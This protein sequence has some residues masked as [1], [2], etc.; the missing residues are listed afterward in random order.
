MVLETTQRVNA[1]QFWQMSQSDD[2]HQELIHGEIHEM[3][4]TGWL[5]GDVTSILS[6]H[7]QSHVLSNK[8]G[9]VTAAE[10]GFRLNDD[11]VLAPDIGFI[12]AERV[13]EKLPDGFVPL[14]PDL[15]VEVMSPSN[16]AS[17]MSQKIKLF[18]QHG[19]QLVWV[20][21]PTTKKMDVYQSIDGETKVDFLDINDTLTGGEVLPDF[22][23][24]L[25]ELF[26]T[27]DLDDE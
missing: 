21:H 15:A 16:S 18:F 17:E 7:I 27:N 6:M 2:I 14:A 11:T 23:L 19:T 8:L 10:T 24:S 13:P 5:H 3:A 25:S 22:S 12:R 1:D 4:P 9:R 26:E 20:V